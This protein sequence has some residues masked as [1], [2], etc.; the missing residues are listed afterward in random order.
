[1]RQTALRGN[2]R[3][4]VACQ[5]R[6][7]I[8]SAVEAESKDSN[9]GRTAGIRHAADTNVTCGCASVVLQFGS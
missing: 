3:V 7:A 9:F 6:D 4:C 8:L 1:M 5:P 2:C